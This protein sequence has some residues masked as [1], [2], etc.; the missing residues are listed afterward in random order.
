MNCADDQKFYFCFAM[1]T[2]N[3][4][5]CDSEFLESK[6]LS[7]DDFEALDEEAQSEI[8]N[9]R[10]EYAI[11]RMKELL[12]EQGFKVYKEF[13]NES[14]GLGVLFL[15]ENSLPAFDHIFRSIS[16]YMYIEVIDFTTMTRQS[17]CDGEYDTGSL[18][19]DPEEYIETVKSLLVELKKM[20]IVPEKPSLDQIPVWHILG[21]CALRFKN[22]LMPVDG[23]EV[24]FWEY[25]QDDDGNDDIDHEAYNV[26]VTFKSRTVSCYAWLVDCQSSPRVNWD[27]IG[28]SYDMHIEENLDIDENLEDDARRSIIDKFE[29]HVRQL[30]KKSCKKP[31]NG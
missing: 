14:S 21:E 17:Y 12:E 11:G 27:N 22:D 15:G 3:D 9:E 10:N 31:S 4:C 18:S 25:C 30:F 16:E 13:N 5:G 20:K 28:D 26:D 2:V 24:G 29:A 8:T 1:S 23:L 6:G 7:E 19:D